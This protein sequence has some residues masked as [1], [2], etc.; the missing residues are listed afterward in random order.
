[1]KTTLLAIAITL[2]AFIVQAD[3]DKSDWGH[4]ERSRTPVSNGYEPVAQTISSGGCTVTSVPGSLG[5]QLTFTCPETTWRVYVRNTDKGLQI[6]RAELRRKPNDP[7]IR[8]I[9]EANIAEIF[10]PYHDGSWQTRLSDNQF[11]TGPLCIRPMTA[12]DISGA[13]AE[14]ITMPGDV[15]P[16]AAVEIRDRGLAWMCKWDNTSKGG[17]KGSRSRR[18]QDMVVWG[19]WDTGNY[20]YSIEYTFRDDG[21]ISFRAG[22][23][24]FDNPGFPERAHMHDVLWRVDIDLNGDKLDTASLASHNENVAQFSATDTDVAFNNGIEGAATLDPLTFGALVIEDALKNSRGNP[25]GYE[26]VP[27]RRGIS[28]HNEAWCR[29]DVWVT[30][31]HGNESAVP[32]SWSPPDEYLLGSSSKPWGIYNQESIG[33]RDIVVWHSSPL[34]HEPHDEDQDANDTSNKFQSLTLIHWTGFDLVPHNLFDANPLGAPHS[35]L[36]D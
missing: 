15:E 13:A 3:D 28:R 16:T 33:A 11:C 12:A 21:Q 2:T 34:H 10:V 36:C 32:A 1:M 18:G 27:F 31:Y 9:Y 19:T 30:R 17:G 35:S 5:Q 4:D 22:A 26:L 8:V 29:D 6:R 23:T 14:L 20:D 24:G 7:F 25:I